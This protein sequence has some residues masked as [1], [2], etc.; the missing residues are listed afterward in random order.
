MTMCAKISDIQNR[1]LSWRKISLNS[2]TNA[3]LVPERVSVRNLILELKDQID[4]LILVPLNQYLM[5]I[6]AV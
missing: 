4:R 2:C 5:L 6:L 1:A 3:A